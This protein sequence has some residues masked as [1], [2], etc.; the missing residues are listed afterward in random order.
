MNKILNSLN[1]IT[2]QYLSHSKNKNKNI[3]NKLAFENFLE[4]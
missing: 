4:S 1:T 3:E 2:S